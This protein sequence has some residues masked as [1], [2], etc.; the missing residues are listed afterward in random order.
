MEY[1]N[2]RPTKKFF[3]DML[4]ADIPLE[5]AILDLVDNSID[6]LSRWRN[7]DLSDNLLLGIENTPSQEPA[8]ISIEITE[9]YIEITDDCGGISRADAI[10]HVF[11]IGRVIP[12]EHL[13]I[14]VYGIG[15]KRAIFK[16]G[17]TFRLTSRTQDD[18]FTVELPDIDEW[19]EDDSP[20]WNIPIKDGAPAKSIKTP[21]TQLR[22]SELR[23]PIR[24]RIKEGTLLASLRTALERTYFLFLDRFV[25]VTLNRQKVTATPLPFG[26]SDDLKPAI[27]RFEIPEDQ[28]RVTIVAGI[29]PP[30]QDEWTAARA[31]WYII[32]NGRVVV[33]AEKTEVTGWGTKFLPQ[34]HT[35]KYRAFVGMAF[36]F[37][38]NP[39]AL[40]WTTTKRGIN[41]DSIVY[42]KSQPHMSKVARE[43]LSFINRWYPGEVPEEPAERQV[44][45]AV[46]S[47]DLRTISA[48]QSQ[49]FTVPAAKPRKPSKTRIQFDATLNELERARRCIGK[50][51]SGVRIGRHA[52]EYFLRNEC[53]DD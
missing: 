45:V 30:Q 5:D 18:V 23:E 46:R 42:Q 37:S 41:R 13:L 28:V 43:V 50:N 1:V 49:S 3:I 48:R 8:N 29:A 7:I 35:S 36:F 21:G 10:D 16:I 53:G 12:A 22:I 9:K 26:E 34:F 47:Q 39:A 15:M 51:W 11:R 6:A 31:G 27:E 4:T 24:R 17:N 19:A 52:F 33:S 40:P 2:A 14:G 38:E 44:A 25:T 20:D 32:C